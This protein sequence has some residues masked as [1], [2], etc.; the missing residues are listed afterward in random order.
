LDSQHDPS[1]PFVSTDQP[2]SP[3]KRRGRRLNAPS[4]RWQHQ[5]LIDRLIRPIMF[6]KDRADEETLTQIRNGLFVAARQILG[7][8]GLTPRQQKRLKALAQAG[9]PSVTSRTLQG[10]QSGFPDP[11]VRQLRRELRD[12]E[13]LRWA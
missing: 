7:V 1:N 12:I 10:W 5:A 13:E 6:R 8:E 9:K 3:A 2:V 11:R 4:G